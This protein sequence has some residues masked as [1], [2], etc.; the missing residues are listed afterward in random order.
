[1]NRFMEICLSVMTIHLHVARLSNNYLD[2]KDSWEFQI[3]QLSSLSSGGSL[4]LP[5]LSS[6]AQLY[7]ISSTLDD[8]L[9]SFLYIKWGLWALAFGE[10]LF[11]RIV[12]QGD[13]LASQPNDKHKSESNH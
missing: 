2:C 6:Q 8:A 7:R 9:Q 1:M 4:L 12:L 11:I 13:I 3:L 10:T 5:L